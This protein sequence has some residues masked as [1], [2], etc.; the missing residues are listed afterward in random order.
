[1]AGARA[2][3]VDR[4]RIWRNS[5]SAAPQDSFQLSTDPFFVE[6]VVDVVWLH[7]NPPERAVV[8]CVDEKSQIQA[9]DRSQ[10]ALP[11]MPRM[12]NGVP[13]T[14]SAQH[15]QPVRHLQH[16]R[17]TV[18]SE[19]HAATGGR[20]Q[21]V[22]GRHRQGRAR[23]PEC[24]WSAITTPP[25]TPPRSRRAGQAPALPRPLHPDRLVLDEPGRALVRPAD[26]QA[27]PPPSTSP[28]RP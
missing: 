27:D 1:M 12:P 10:P 24:T 16:R 19:L 18:I 11:M 14:T 4:R 6:K 9:L 23:R 17:R 22:P 3:E 25:T 5:T 13:M 21:E 8:L 28:S 7:H 20:V 2:V 15:H 26:R